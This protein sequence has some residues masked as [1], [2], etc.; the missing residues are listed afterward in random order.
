MQHLEY[1]NIDHELW[2]LRHA[3][4]PSTLNVL[5]TLESMSRVSLLCCIGLRHLHGEDGKGWRKIF[6]G[7]GSS[8]ISQ[9]RGFFL[10]GSATLGFRNRSLGL[11]YLGGFVARASSVGISTFIPLFVNTY[12]ISSGICDQKDSDSDSIK[13]HCREA[14][15]LAAKLTGVS[16]TAALAFALVFGFSADKYRHSNAVLVLA[17]LVGLSGYVA[18]GALDNPRTDRPSGTPFVYVIMIM[19]GFGQIGTIVCSLALL[20]Q[21]VLGVGIK[22]SHHNGDEDSAMLLP[23]LQAAESYEHM[24]GEIAGA[25]SLA[26]GLGILLLT[27]I[28][29][30]LFDQVSTAAP[31]YILASFNAALIVA[32]IFDAILSKAH[33][34]EHG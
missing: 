11:A 23:K 3:S 8:D 32:C 22:Q 18:L 5:L 19:I 30:V 25:Y 31:F 29:G 2:L 20:G 4:P 6:G 1:P 14:Y 13:L 17:A 15:T 7:V 16:Q 24:K 26:G 28:G 10:L 9:Q 33:K 12:F 34:I 27:K 21:C